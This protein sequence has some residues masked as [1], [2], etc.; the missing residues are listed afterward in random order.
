MADEII[1]FLETDLPGEDPI[2]AVF[3]H[4]EE[5]TTIKTG[6]TV[7]RKI[8]IAQEVLLKK[9]LEADDTLRR[10]MYLE[11]RLEGASTAAH[12]V[13]FSWYS[14]ETHELAV[15]DP[16][17]GTN[18]AIERLDKSGQKVR[19]VGGPGAR[20]FGLRAAACAP[21]SPSVRKALGEGRDLRVAAVGG[22]TA[23]IDVVDFGVL[24]GSLESKRV[25]VQR[26]ADS[27]K[28]GT[29]I[30]T[31]EKAKQASLVAI[32][33]DLRHN[34]V[35]KHLARPGDERRLISL[36]AVGN[37]VNWTAKDKAVL[38]TYVD[39]TFLVKDSAIV[40]YA[41][42]VADQ[43]H[44]EDD[45]LAAFMAYFKGL[46]KQPPDSFEVYDDDFVIIA[47]SEDAEPRSL[48][49]VLSDH[50]AAVDG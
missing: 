5:L 6:R 36:V 23:Q 13:E 38:D 42:Y 48:R 31:I 39:F 16:I 41:K 17:P 18:C 47:P 10:R 24:L 33:L 19:V 2:S 9:Y 45:H 3:R 21:Q 28:L 14:T 20:S 29:G 15:G 44:G 4:F 12:K 46:T 43:E 35:I 26:F 8:G 25:G 11:R 7:G 27:N 49:Q 1:E 37:G 40:R 32:D 22:D 30:Q 50:I 34:G